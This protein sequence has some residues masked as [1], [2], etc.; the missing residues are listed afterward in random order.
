ML[1]KRFALLAFA[2]FVVFA[3]PFAFPGP[4]D[5]FSDPSPAVMAVGSH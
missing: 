4:K 5:L 2:A 3:T 1:A